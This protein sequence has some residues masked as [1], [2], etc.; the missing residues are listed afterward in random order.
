MAA[1]ISRA[2]ALTDNVFSEDENN[3][4]ANES[5]FFYESGNAEE[6]E[7]KELC[8]HTGEQIS[9]GKIVSEKNL[10]DDTCNISTF[11]V[12]DRKKEWILDSG[13]TAHMCSDEMAIK[14][15]RAPQKRHVIIANN[16]AIEIKCVGSV[17]ECIEIE[18]KKSVIRIDD[19]QCIPDICANLF[20]VSKLVKKNYKVIFDINGAK[21][22]D[23]H[24]KVI[25]I[26]SLVNDLFKLDRCVENEYAAFASKAILWH[27]RLGHVSASSMKFLTKKCKEH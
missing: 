8:D 10:S 13:A 16:E 5:V 1:V 7:K 22:Y 26:A 6:V 3:E 17:D 27:K 11:F 18:G 19:V 25:A 9:D 14:N 24:K 15:A 12:G 4:L 20:S 21:I 2:T 23:E